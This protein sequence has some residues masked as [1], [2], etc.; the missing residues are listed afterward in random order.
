MN[1]PFHLV[2][3]P[4]SYMVILSVFS[5][6]VNPQN[7]QNSDWIFGTI[8]QFVIIYKICINIL[9]IVIYRKN[10]CERYAP[11]L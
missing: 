4:T 6:S 11:V 5:D 1:S 3:C 8:S 7:S 2:S 10:T 9:R